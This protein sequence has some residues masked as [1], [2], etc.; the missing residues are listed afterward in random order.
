MGCLPENSPAMKD[1]LDAGKVIESIELPTLSDG[2]AGG[3]GLNSITYS[4]C[5]ELIDSIVLVSEEEI[6]QAIR[7]VLETEQMIIEGAAGVAVAGF[8]KSFSKY[9]AKKVAIIL[10][11][12][13]IDYELIKK[14]I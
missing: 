8:L 12:R 11:G 14:I 7:L 4:L 3:V 1:S 6:T 10:C 9:K 2:T 5:K 13:N